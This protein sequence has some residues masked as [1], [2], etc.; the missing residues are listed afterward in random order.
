MVEVILS[1][2]EWIGIV[3]A[4]GIATALGLGVYFTSNYLIGAY[5]TDDLKDPMSNLF[6]VVGTL[7]ALMLSLSFAEVIYQNTGINNALEREAS[8]I[9]DTF[10]DLKQF[11][12][13]GTRALRM[14]LVT[15][16][17]SVI[18]DDWKSLAS[19]QLSQ[20]SKSV[21]GEI[22]DNITILEA[23]SEIQKR[24]ISRIDADIDVISDSRLIR[25]DN[26]LAETP[27][28]VYVIVF[29]F[30]VTMACFGAYKTNTPIVVLLALYTSFIGLV[31]YMILSF[32]DPF[33][34]AFGVAP[35]T[36]ERLVEIMRIED[37]LD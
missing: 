34:G 10:R 5:T 3:A 29:G 15:Y 21:F 1:L 13:E 25:I 30:L 23:Q 6:R 31:L 19:D 33:Q 35:T 14:L 8:A 17:E 26:A 12:E 4:M 18:E 16:T 24:I 9:A 32:S 22:I 27:L 20:R 11:D 2:P 36:F 37:G 7:I 28:Y